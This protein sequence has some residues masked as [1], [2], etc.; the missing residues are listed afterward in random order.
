MAW[1]LAGAVLI[2]LVAG[3]LFGFLSAVAFSQPTGGLSV[4]DTE[5]AGAE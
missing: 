4:E 1:Q 3:A 5:Q 2:G